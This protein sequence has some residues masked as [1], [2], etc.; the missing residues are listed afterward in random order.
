MLLCDF[1]CKYIT[2]YVQQEADSYKESHVKRNAFDI[3]M[4]G[5]LNDSYLPQKIEKDKLI[6]TER[7]YNMVVDYLQKV[8][9]G[10][11]HEN[12]ESCG[13]RVA[14]VLRDTLWYL[15]THHEK[16]KERSNPLPKA[17]EIF[18][19]HN[20]WKQN[21]HRQPSLTQEGLYSHEQSI[22][23]VLMLPMVV[24]Q[25]NSVLA[26]D[27]SDLCKAMTK[28]R[29][30][31]EQSTV[32]VEK[33]R[34][35]TIPVR[36]TETHS[37]LTTIAASVVCPQ[38]YQELQR[39]LDKNPPYTPVDVGDF[40]TVDRFERRKYIANIQLV[41]DVSMYAMPYGNCLGT[42]TILWKIERN[43]ENHESRN[44]GVILE[45]S[46]KLPLYSTREMR[47]S[48]IQT[49]SKKANV[50]PMVLRAIYRELFNDSAAAA[51]LREEDLDHRVVSFFMESEQPDLLLDLRK[52]NG[53]PGSTMFN[54]F[55]EETAKYFEEQAQVH[56]RRHE[57]NFT[58]LPVAISVEELRLKVKERLPEGTPVPSS[59]W[60]RLQ[61]WPPNPY[62]A[63]ALKHTFRL[64]V[65]FAVQ[66]RLLRSEHIDSKYATTQYKYLKQFACKYKDH[67]RLICVDDKAIVPVGNPSQPVSTGVRGHN[68][69]LTPI[70]GTLAALDHD[71]HVGGLVPSV[72]LLAE[73]PERA[74][75][76]FYRGKVC[77]TVKEKVFQPSSPGRHTAEIARAL[78]E[79]ASNDD[80]TLDVPILLIFSDGGPD[81]RVTF[82]TVKVALLALFLALDLDVLYAARCAPH[83]SW[84]NPAERTMSLLNLALQNVALER[85][86][87][88]EGLEKLI[89]GKSDLNSVRRT[90]ERHPDLKEGFKAAMQPVIR[91]VSERFRKMRLKEEKVRTFPAALD[92]EIE[93]I[94]SI[95]S[96]I[97]EE[98]TPR[99][100]VTMTSKDWAKRQQITSFL[101]KHS[102][103]THYTF[104]LKKC[105]S[106]SCNV[107]VLSPVR[108]PAEVFST[109]SFLPDPMLDPSGEH[110]L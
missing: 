52:L 93:E 27:L 83:G 97:D 54:T 48:F 26:R 56:D 79:H 49:Y 107:C 85:G 33:A 103:Q 94:M 73:I 67:A 66:T 88:S 106:D 20:K 25:R 101:E 31:L 96:I 51:S 69:S 60:L 62:A 44:G 21:R 38:Q 8:N 46:K 86:C 10:F 71:W 92:E 53:N 64:D 87:M 78:R 43:S 37:A 55:W 74:E 11:T 40:V 75:D 5:R 36:T 90:A 82:Q 108:L 24:T 77:V 2:Y 28:Y 7:L 14:I 100:A 63:R 99:D 32:R 39:H 19:N 42:V 35:S 81:H 50:K 4:S 76:T 18:Q 91:L 30:Y 59:E 105:T 23:A 22:S 68:R 80:V 110:Y 65:K 16:F 12:A 61:F 102:K 95:L 70:G 58:Y 57:H 17:F 98:I 89:S 15:D 109:L 45:V 9:A 13:K 47:R 72:M 29:L 84:I 3:M 34:S 104:Q 1:Q 6:V 41:S